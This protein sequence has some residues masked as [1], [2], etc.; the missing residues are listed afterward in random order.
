MPLQ[1][2]IISTKKLAHDAGLI[3]VVHYPTLEEFKGGFLMEGAESSG[4]T[5]TM[6]RTIG[7]SVAPSSKD[8]STRLPTVIYHTYDEN[9]RAPLIER[10]ELPEI[11]VTNGSTLVNEEIVF[12]VSEDECN[13]KIREIYDKVRDE[14]E[15]CKSEIRI[16]IR[17]SKCPSIVL[18]DIPGL[19]K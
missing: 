16:Y 8:T 5:M 12:N 4:K 17:S 2:L 11:K 13:K 15:L 7:A 14:L 1:Q 9:S 18:I 10:L 3:D 19:V 6:V